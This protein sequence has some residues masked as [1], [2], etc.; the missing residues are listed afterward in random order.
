[1]KNKMLNFTIIII[2]VT[3]IEEFTFHNYLKN[4]IVFYSPNFSVILSYKITKTSN[5][6]TM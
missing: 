4:V 3:V 5:I 6:N 2:R 1:M